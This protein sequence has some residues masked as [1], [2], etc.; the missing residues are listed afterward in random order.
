MLRR[1]IPG[2]HGAP[3]V[4]DITAPSPKPPDPRAHTV[5]SAASTFEANR[6]IVPAAGIFTAAN[7]GLAA[8]E[9]TQ[10]RQP[11]GPCPGGYGD[12]E[13][14][15]GGAVTD[16]DHLARA[17]SRIAFK[18]RHR[19]GRIYPFLADF[20]Q[21]DR[22]TAPVA[23]TNLIFVKA[24]SCFTNINLPHSQEICIFSVSIFWEFLLAYCC[25]AH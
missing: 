10:R 8:S 23:L 22:I 7:G 1:P 4:G 9:T 6:P 17:T 2:K 14:G 11:V 21:Q 20:C 19:P 5:A 12:V 13:S 25:I 3:K 16:A 18:S 24:N 15:C